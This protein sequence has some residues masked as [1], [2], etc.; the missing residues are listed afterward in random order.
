MTMMMVPA[1]HTSRSAAAAVLGVGSV[2]AV[3]VPG[4]TRATSAD[5]VGVDIEAA[6]SAA[7]SQSAAAAGGDANGT[8]PSEQQQQQEGQ[9]SQKGVEADKAAWGPWLALH[10]V[11]EVQE[12]LPAIS[13]ESSACLCR[14]LQLMA[15]TDALPPSAAASAAKGDGGGAMAAG[16]NQ[17]G[18]LIDAAAVIADDGS[19]KA[20]GG[21]G[22]GDDVKPLDKRFR[23][24][25]AFAALAALQEDV[26]DRGVAPGDDDGDDYEEG[27][28][29]SPMD[30]ALAVLC[31]QLCTSGQ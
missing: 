14:L 16:G 17:R 26:V 1:G 8:A 25:V 31:P 24:S 6:A 29:W 28:G 18:G 5:D 23:D 3:P 15:M 11:L 13:K 30:D 22:R 4:D 21:M 2:T 20:A 12:H 7:S 10:H 19:G 9:Q 27:L